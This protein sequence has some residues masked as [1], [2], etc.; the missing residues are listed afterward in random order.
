MTVGPSAL[1]ISN[2]SSLGLR[3]QLTPRACVPKCL[4]HEEESLALTP[5]SPPLRISFSL[6]CTSTRIASIFNQVPSRT[7]S[8]S[9]RNAIGAVSRFGA[10]KI[11]SHISNMK[12]VNAIPF[13][14][15]CPCHC[16]FSKW[17]KTTCSTLCPPTHL[18]ENPPGAFG[19]GTLSLT[20]SI[21]SVGGSQ[22]DSA[23]GIANFHLQGGTLNF[24]HV[25]KRLTPS[26]PSRFGVLDAGNSVAP[27]TAFFFRKRFSTAE[28][29]PSL[30]FLCSW[31]LAYRCSAS[32]CKSN[33]S[34]KFS[35]ALITK[36]R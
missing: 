24:L 19:S 30:F 12:S 28:R 35:V 16:S 26:S 32:Q 11:E 7:D 33:V 15:C 25:F 6:D 18:R 14:Q 9:S 13:S 27:K 5:W 34:S 10:A 21:V 4:S 17:L 8:G 23:S 29:A 3:A 20:P 22:R 31:F 36:R 1:A 2:I